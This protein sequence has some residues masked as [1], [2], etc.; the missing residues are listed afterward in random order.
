MSIRNITANYLQMKKRHTNQ[1][2]YLVI[3][4]ENI[5]LLKPTAAVL[6]SRTIFLIRGNIL[7]LMDA[8]S[9]W[10]ENVGMMERHRS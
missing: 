7:F 5:S 4:Y 3:F 1:P 2:V 10:S 9:S 6:P 8:V